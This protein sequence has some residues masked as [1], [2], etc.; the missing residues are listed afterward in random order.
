MTFPVDA[1]VSDLAR[2]LADSPAA[3]LVAEPGAGKSTRVPLALAQA[4]W[5][6]GKVLLLEPRRLAARATA[7]FMAQNLGQRLGQSVGLRTRLD[8]FTGPDVRVEV[9]T[10]GV[11]ARML[12][13]DPALEGYQLIIFDEF[14]ERSLQADLG[15]ALARQSQQLLREDLRL[16]VMSATLDTG[17]LSALLGGAP[18]IDVPGRCYPVAISH[19]PPA[20]RDRWADQAVEVI[21][22]LSP[23]SGTV[24]VFLPGQREIRHLAARLE[25]LLPDT[26]KVQTLY[27]EMPAEAQQAV[28]TDCPDSAGRVVLATAI[29]Q[30]SLTLQAVD[31]VVDAGF[32]RR[33]V[34]DAGR[35]ITRLET[36]RLS[37]H[38]A[39]QRAGRAGR[40]GPGR[41]IRLWPE[42]EVLDMASPAEIRH[43]DLSDLALTLAAWGCRDAAELDWLDPPPE[44]AWQLSRQSL[45]E[46]GALDLD[47]NLTALGAAMQSLPL[48]PRLARLRLAGDEHGMPRT[49]AALAAILSERDPLPERGDADIEARLRW[50]LEGPGRQQRYWQRLLR[51]LGG[52]QQDQSPASLSI[53][54]LLALAWPDRLALRQG[55]E[56]RYRL[57]QGQGAVLPEGDPLAAEELLVM[58]ELGGNREGDAVCRLAAPVT[59]QRLF[60]LFADRIREHESA[61]WDDALGRVR[62][63][64]ETRLGALV[65]RREELPRPGPEAAQA[66][67]VDQVRQHG[68]DWLAW[69]EGSRQWRARAARAR[70]L[71]GDP[72]PDLS[73]QALLATLDQWLVPW[74]GGVSGREQLDRLPLREMLAALCPARGQELE[75]WLPATFT[76]A[77]GRQWKIDYTAVGQPVLA[78]P[79]QAMF[80]CR[81]TPA[82]ADGRLT[83]TLHLL[84]PA[85]RPLAVTSDLASFW[86]QGYP[87]VRRDMRGR[88]PKHAW[89]EDP[90]AGAGKKQEQ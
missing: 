24:L 11:L 13:Q 59:R 63:L 51:Q 50:L 15:L 16:L 75:Q 55:R 74:L 54:E 33:P 73:D 39:D 42:S 80:G 12:L 85:R 56:G 26:V 3:I 57:A 44:A 68:L 48:P 2:M 83:L 47:G 36:V 89:P 10:E 60:A 82:L 17:P 71:F 14:H 32:E 28:L 30:T 46:M 65:L 78:L 31:T 41:C 20:R 49:A 5:C 29:A 79:V 58:P 37:R 77:D 18:V 72:W 19:R 6:H 45:Q 70:E 76:S 25:S 21:R 27:G 38:T 53:G 86:Q 40:T 62:G 66:L 1:I 90:L 35:G 7:Q 43:A 69:D 8:T 9:V 81:Q 52:D 64:R 67:I 84:S 87:Q 23:S 4:P 22:E 34:F 61:R 88:Y